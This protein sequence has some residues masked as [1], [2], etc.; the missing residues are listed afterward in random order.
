VAAAALAARKRARTSGVTIVTW[1]VREFNREELLIAGLR[2]ENPDT[3]LC[4]LLE[5]TPA[6]V[7]AAFLHMRDNLRNP[8]K[9]SA[10]CADT[11]A[12]QGLKLFA[13]SILARIE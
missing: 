3:F 1:N 9:T 10:E 13:R 4:R 8:T 6:D 7:V 5:D 12:A 11:L 2:A